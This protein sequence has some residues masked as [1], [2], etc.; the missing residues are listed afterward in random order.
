MAA[1]HDDGDGNTGRERRIS[2]V[3]ERLEASAG[4]KLVAWE[5][6]AL[7]A[8]ERENFWRHVIAV[9]NGSF[10]TDFERLMEAA[11]RCPSPRRWRVPRSRRSYGR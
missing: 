4:R 5:S 8:K 2:E 10:A 6:D 9:E 7:P 1:R 3:K 11:W